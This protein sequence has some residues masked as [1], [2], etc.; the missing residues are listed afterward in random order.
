MVDGSI[1]FDSVVVETAWWYSLEFLEISWFVE[2]AR[3]GTMWDGV[4]VLFPSKRQPIFRRAVLWARPRPRPQLLVRFSCRSYVRVIETKGGGR[5]R[6]LEV[7][8]WPLMRNWRWSRCFRGGALFQAVQSTDEQVG[9]ILW[10]YSKIRGKRWFVEI[11]TAEASESGVVVMLE[12]SQGGLL[13]VFKAD[14][15]SENRLKHAKATETGYPWTPRGHQ[16][17][18]WLRR[19]SMRSGSKN[20]YFYSPLTIIFDAI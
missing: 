6:G 3:T 16:T 10:T 4:V 12:V 2:Q 8:E 20:P 9:G 17:A 7:P 13:H 14:F 19:N 5:K 18:S 1:R 11:G 15:K